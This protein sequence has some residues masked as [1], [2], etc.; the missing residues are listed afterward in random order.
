MDM[1][2]SP[3][4][5]RIQWAG[6]VLITG[7]LLWL[8]AP[9]LTPFVF[10]ALLGWLGDPTVDRLQR[11]GWSRHIAVVIVFCTM[12]FIVLVTLVLLLPLIER[13]IV[14]LVE[15]LP[16]YRD[17]FI[18]TVLPWFERHTGLDLM[19]WLIRTACSSSCATIGNAPAAW[20]RRCSGIS[21]A[22]ASRWSAGSRTSCSCPSSPSTSCGIGMC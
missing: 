20:R 18:G 5:R 1:P 16:H 2:L 17:W 9:I 6:I 12:A 10:A 8:L 4:A 11:R 7:L 22:R 14:T 15:S 19:A 3:F 21:R 13:Q